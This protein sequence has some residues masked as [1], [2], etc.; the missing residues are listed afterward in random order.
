MLEMGEITLDIVDA[1]ITKK[2]R[3]PEFYLLPKIH[4]NKTPVPGRPI[5]SGN[6]GPIEKI[7]AFVDFIMK[8][9]PLIVL[10]EGLQ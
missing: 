3:T 2:L 6:G 4:K 9:V 8:P 7:S 10:C 5:V 1:L